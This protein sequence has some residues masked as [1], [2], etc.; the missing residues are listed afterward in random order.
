MRLYSKKTFQYKSNEKIS[1][2][3]YLLINPSHVA[4]PEA[5]QYI[6]IFFVQIQYFS[7][8]KSHTFNLK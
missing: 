4:I 2:T 6:N 1:S 7:A 8:I 5:N 3:K